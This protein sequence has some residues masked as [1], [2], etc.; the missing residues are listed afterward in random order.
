MCYVHQSNQSGAVQLGR[1]IFQNLTELLMADTLYTLSAHFGNRV[2]RGGA[3]TYDMRL[4]AGNWVVASTL[5]NV[6]DG[7]VQDSVTAGV[8]AGHPAA[9]QPLRVEIWRGVGSQQLNVDSVSITGVPIPEPSTLALAAFG[10]LALLAFA[11]RRK[12]R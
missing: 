2:D 10:L 1:G 5:G 12:R 11:R 3:T 9:G 8:V 6:P 7:W 4:I